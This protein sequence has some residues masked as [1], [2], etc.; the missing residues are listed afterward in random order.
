MQTTDK[1]ISTTQVTRVSDMRSLPNLDDEAL[2]LVVKDG[3]CWK[4]NFGKLKHQTYVDVLASIQKIVDAVK[5]DSAASVEKVESI[6]VE[7]KSLAK[8]ANVLCDKLSNDAENISKQLVETSAFLDQKQ[9]KNYNELKTECGN[10][11]YRMQDAK[12]DSIR[13]DMLMID[14][15]IGNSRND[16]N[17]LSI[18]MNSLSAI[19]RKSISR[20]DELSESMSKA[21]TDNKNMHNEVGD[22]INSLSSNLAELTRSLSQLSTA[23]DSDSKAN[24]I[25]AEILSS[26]IDKA[27][28][29][30]DNALSNL[31]TSFSN[32][33]D[34][35]INALEK[36][37][38]ADVEGISNKI[39]ESDNRLFNAISTNIKTLSN[40]MQQLDKSK[41]LQ[42]DNINNE[43]KSIQSL[44]AS[45]FNQLQDAKDSIQQLKDNLSA[46]AKSISSNQKANEK[47][48]QEFE[49]KLYGIVV[50][51]QAEDGSM[52]EDVIQQGDIMRLENEIKELKAALSSIE[53][54][55]KK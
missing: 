26:R 16:I 30:A 22:N 15:N 36:S 47:I 28:Q 31:S 1:P 8:N 21:E 32:N 42:L 14:Q 45:M 6:A 53:V 54:I 24:C 11:L 55:E 7:A 35:K 17:S 29:H 43:I 4:L 13:S 18:G 48:V 41:I 38:S 52:T 23:V 51:E 19:E 39:V 46:C 12:F 10:I 5:D 33:I 9:D 2:L 25:S 44:T 20:I 50:Q 34:S 49:S 40:D 3:T 27:I 37:L